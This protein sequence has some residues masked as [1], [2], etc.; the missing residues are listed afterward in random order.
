MHATPAVL[1]AAPSKT[2]GVAC[3]QQY[4]DPLC[5]ICQRLSSEFLARGKLAFIDSARDPIRRPGK[6]QRSAEATALPV[7][8][9]DATPVCFGDLAYE[10]ET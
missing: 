8:Q 1:A 3:A 9:T 2:N 10:G 7:A 4:T 6:D 5:Q